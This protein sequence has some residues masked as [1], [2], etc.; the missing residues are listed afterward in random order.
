MGIEVIDNTD[1]DA[2][3]RQH[4]EGVKRQL[5][6]RMELALRTNS[7]W[8]DDTGRSKQAFVVRVAQRGWTIGNQFDYARIRNNARTIRGA[9]NYHFRAVQNW[10]RDRW[11]SIVS[12]VGRSA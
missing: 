7:Y 12:E 1:F 9:P 2:A 4:I 6:R 5:A 8:R 3:I 10:I 11:N